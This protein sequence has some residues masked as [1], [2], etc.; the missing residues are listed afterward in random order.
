MPRIRDGLTHRQKL[1]VGAYART[2]DTK[3]ASSV[4]GFG[5]RSGAASK[6]INSPEGRAEIA[7]IQTDILYNEIL[8]LA[9]AKHI[10]LLSNP[11][12]PAGAAVQ[13]IKLAYDRTLGSQEGAQTKELH[14]MSAADIAAALT[15]LRAAATSIVD[16]EANPIDD[17]K[18]LDETDI[19][20]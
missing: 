13:A 17:A 2:S 5:E 10:E 7:R 4:A 15:Q 9:L 1:A 12:T 8:P 20:G 18:P 14:E 3:Y 11:K 6:A 19:F 16:V